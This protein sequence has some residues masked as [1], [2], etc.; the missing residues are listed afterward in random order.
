MDLY[1]PASFDLL[2]RKEP[3]QS[4]SMRHSGKPEPVKMEY[5]MGGLLAAI[6]LYGLRLESPDVETNLTQQL[7]IAPEATAA[8]SPEVFYLPVV[9]ELLPEFGRTEV[10]DSIKSTLSTIVTGLLVELIVR[11][12]PRQPIISGS[13]DRHGAVALSAWTIRFESVA[14]KIRELRRDYLRM[15]VGE[16]YDRILNLWDVV[17]DWRRAPAY[18]QRPPLREL[19]DTSG[20]VGAGTKR[21][22]EDKEGWAVPNKRAALVV[23]LCD[24]D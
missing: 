11:S 14:T 6:V 1:A 2:V 3:M 20:N 22:A 10:D 12:V 23:D 7:R 17:V 19:A 8:A 21:K 24:S 5:H 16:H 15:A 4:N 18:L 9:R 13:W